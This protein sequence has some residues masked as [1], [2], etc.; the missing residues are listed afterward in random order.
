MNKSIQLYPVLSFLTFYMIQIS[1]KTYFAVFGI[2]LYIAAGVAF[3]AYLESSERN[4]KSDIISFII[5]ILF[6]ALFFI[7]P[8]AG[9]MIEK[10]GLL[11]NSANLK[12]WWMPL[13][14]AAIFIP[15][16]FL[17]KNR[18]SNKPLYIPVV[19]SAA[20]P[21]LLTGALLIFFADIRNGAVAAVANIIQTSIID[22]LIKMKE[23]MQISDYYADMLS[24]LILNKETVAK[25]TVYMI[26]A[27]ISSVFVLI[28]Y[29]CDR[30]KPV[31]KDNAF[32][33]REFRL[34]DNLVWILILGG[35]LI[36]A[37]NEG[38]KYVSYNVIALFAL[39]YFFQGL[40]VVN[41]AFDKFQVSIFIRSLLFLFIFLY[42]TVV[43]SIIVLIGIFS[44]WFKPK[45]LE[46]DS[47]NTDKKENDNGRNF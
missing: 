14:I 23:T 17:Y 7:L 5:Y 22:T 9:S 45:W 3:L 6:T 46:K 32:I 40:Q 12:I 16:F 8:S 47:S 25:Q 44:I 33:I 24:Y 30:M 28:T 27:A 35:F 36:L 19:I 39:L 1:S 34:P 20:V 37:Q 41:K 21:A 11:L 18:K 31:F 2:F 38:L 26:P 13:Y 29:M 15:V 42:C 10:T 4:R 43:A